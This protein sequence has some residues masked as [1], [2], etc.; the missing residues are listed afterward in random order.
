MKPSLGLG[1]ALLAIGLF[2][3]LATFGSGSP[4][5]IIAVGPIGAGIANIVG[6]LRE[7]ATLASANLC[8][9]CGVRGL[10]H[11]R[12]D[13]SVCGQMYRLGDRLDSVGRCDCNYHGDDRVTLSGGMKLPVPKQPGIPP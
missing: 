8:P 3:T 12:H 4:I 1:V 10:N 13:E 9:N 6:A 5:F 7:D 11:V 2:I